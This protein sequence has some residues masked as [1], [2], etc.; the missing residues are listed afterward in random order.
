MER[1]MMRMTQTEILQTLIRWDEAVADDLNL[2]LVR[3]GLEVRM[4]D[5]ALRVDGLAVAVRGGSGRVEALRELVLRLGRRVGLV[6]YDEDLV[7]E[8]GVMEDS[9]VGI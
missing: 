9:K 8:E 1:A 5:G 4:Q 7:G 6:L 3:D 2:G